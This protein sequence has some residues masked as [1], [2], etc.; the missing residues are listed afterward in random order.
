M[1]NSA[2]AEHR[3]RLRQ[4]SRRWWLRLRW[5]GGSRALVRSFGQ[6][7]CRARGTRAPPRSAA[8]P[9]GDIIAT[10]YFAGSLQNASA[11]EGSVH[12]A[13]GQDLFVARFRSSGELTWLVRAGG[14]GADIGRAIAVRNATQGPAT[15]AVTGQAGSDAAFGTHTIASKSQ[16]GLAVIATLSAETGEFLGVAHTGGEESVSG[17][18][19]AIVGD[20][21]IAGTTS[22]PALVKLRAEG[23][24]RS[25]EQAGE[26]PRSSRS[27]SPRGELIER[28]YCSNV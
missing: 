5:W 16:F 6:R 1:A 14:Q 20:E 21:F 3:R 17:Q 18:A 23:D 25:L 28:A 15:V 2:A 24:D 7:L 8:L 19:L 22:V 11:P 4:L 9:S 13:G 26:L 10:G 12:S 27:H